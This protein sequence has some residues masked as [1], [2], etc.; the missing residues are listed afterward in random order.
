MRTVIAPAFE[1]PP[2]WRALTEEPLV[3]HRRSE[4]T[5]N[6]KLVLFAH[7]LGGTRYGKGATW[8]R[9]PR[10]LFEDLPEIDVGL[11]QYRTLTGRF[12][13]TKSV[14]L[15]VE[16]RV[17]ADL[18]RDQL[19]QYSTIVL[20]GHS[21]GG[22]LC[23]SVIHELVTRDDRDTL[24]RVGGLVLMATPQLGSLRVPSFMGA[25][26]QD[27]RALAPHGNFVDAINRTFQDHLALDESIHSLRKITIPTW[28]VEGAHDRWVDSLSAGIGLP[29]SRR[30]TVRG[31]HTSIV[32]PPDRNAA[33]YQWVKT[34][35]S[36]A[37]HR[38]KYDVF[39]AAAMAAHD[40]D[41]DYAEDRAA[42]LSLI[43]VL[44]KKCGFDSVFYAGENLPTKD[45]FDPKA[46]ALSEDLAALRNSRYFI[47]Y[48]P[49]RL[50]SSVLYEAGWALVL[51]KPSI[52][53]IRG[54]QQ[55]D[56]G[57]PFLLNDASQA[58]KERRVR[59]FKCPNTPGMLQAFSRY[60]A[61]LFRYTDE[62]KE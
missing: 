16:S 6:A 50:P 53:V 47:M 33:A 57:L 28:A 60:G 29:S 41:P 55:P 35:I 26:S 5:R 56:E 61:N 51:G 21:M 22:L 36:T 58:F 34:K 24:A 62:A 13:F 14:S 9:F 8:G 4:P 1:D 3:V 44:K 59:I 38:F 31:S 23:K 54:D 15:E 39:L 25:F 52:Y 46:L 17:F 27:F 10:L 18:L 19:A 43:Q 42:V 7:G 2:D 45:A 48:Y 30:K 20:I 37:L 12:A 49:K 40:R 11:Y 32:K